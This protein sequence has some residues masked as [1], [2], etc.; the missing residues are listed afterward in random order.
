MK[1][2]HHHLVLKIIIGTILVIF[3]LLILSTQEEKSPT[4]GVPPG[5]RGPTNPP[6]VIGPTTP[7]PKR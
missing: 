4:P 7:P 3:A 1:T 2:A 5:F 6:H